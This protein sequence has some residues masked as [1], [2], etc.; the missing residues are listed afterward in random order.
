[1]HGYKWPINC[2]RTRTPEDQVAKGALVGCWASFAPPLLRGA[3][4]SGSDHSPRAAAGVPLAVLTLSPPAGS[5]RGGLRGRADGAAST[6]GDA[7]FAETDTGAFPY[8]R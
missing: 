8:N 5:M 4:G 6:G 7:T 1:M 2:T 3:V